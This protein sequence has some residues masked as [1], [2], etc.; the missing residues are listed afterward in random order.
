MIND[1][2]SEKTQMKITFK[3]KIF[4]NEKGV[5]TIQFILWKFAFI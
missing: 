1:D 2:L 4:K 3:M 5:A